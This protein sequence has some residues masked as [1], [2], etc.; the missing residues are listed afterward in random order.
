VTARPARQVDG[1]PHRVDRTV[2]SGNKITVLITAWT[3]M[4]WVTLVAQ[5]LFAGISIYQMAVVHVVMTP[6]ATTWM[7]I[8]AAILIPRDPA[9]ILGRVNL[10]LST[11][12][13]VF[14]RCVVRSMITTANLDEEKEHVI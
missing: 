2:M 1:T 6:R 7:S 14:E 9:R 12:G 13:L 10:H 3:V 8:S 11:M 5:C 4:R